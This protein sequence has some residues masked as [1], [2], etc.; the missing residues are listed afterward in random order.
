MTRIELIDL[1]AK[2]M[3]LFVAIAAI[4]WAVWVVDHTERKYKVIV[5]EIISI[6][7]DV[8]LIQKNRH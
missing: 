8:S 3:W 5:D 6:S 4:L 1:I 7:K 2:I